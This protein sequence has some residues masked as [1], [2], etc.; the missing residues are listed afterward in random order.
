ML[1]RD[2]MLSGVVQIDETYYGSKVRGRSTARYSPKYA[3][4]GAVE[5]GEHGRLKLEVVKQP[6]A[7][8]AASFIRRN[9]ALGAVIHSDESR[10]Y[11]SLKYTYEHATVNHSEHQY[12]YEGVTSNKIE[13]AWMHTKRMLRGI[14]IRVSGKHLP[15]YGREFQFR[16]N[17]RHMSS[18]EQ[19]DQWFGQSF[20]KVLTYK[21]L[22]A[23]KSVQPLALR[24]WARKRAA[25]PVQLKLGL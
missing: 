17:T 7:T 14:H 8:V 13:N 20:G 9:I 11:H 23:A 10:I 5:K 24:G 25:M 16:Y 1:E 3:I 12:V 21:Q 22:V 6:D 2:F 4:M 18:G 15:L 19:F